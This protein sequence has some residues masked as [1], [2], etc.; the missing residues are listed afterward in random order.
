LAVVVLFKRIFVDLR[1]LVPLFGIYNANI[2]LESHLRDT[3]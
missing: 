1:L 3:E 2:P